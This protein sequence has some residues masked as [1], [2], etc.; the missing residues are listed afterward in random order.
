MDQD[1]RLLALNAR[2]GDG[3]FWKHPECVNCKLIFTS[4]NKEWLEH[5]GTLCGQ[6]KPTLVRA[7]NAANCFANAKPLWALTTFVNPLFNEYRDKPVAACLDE[8]DKLHFY[9]WYLDDG[10]TME[11]R[12]SFRG[13]RMPYRYDLCIGNF[14]QGQPDLEAYFLQ[15]VSVIFADVL[16]GTTPGRIA[17]NNSKASARNKTWHM[18]V[19]VGRA[20]VLG[21]RSFNVPG[22][23]N[24]LRCNL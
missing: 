19:C 9:Y 22:F 11:R 14:L 20:C 2:T 8:M 7:G 4:T 5:K 16:R 18:P 1:L 21:A 10:C 12:D 24:K 15:R 6:R 23:E 3:S 13:R 17:K